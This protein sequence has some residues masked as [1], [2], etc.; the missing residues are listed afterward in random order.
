VTGLCECGCGEAAPIARMTRKSRGHVK[1]QPVRFI[2]GHRNR[3]REVSPQT[4]AKISASTLGRKV[5]DETRAKLSAAGWKGDDANYFS[6]HEWLRKHYPKTGI[7]EEC[8]AKGPTDFAFQ[9]HPE[10][11][12]RNR[13]DYAEW[14]RSCHTA[15]DRE[16]DEQGRWVAA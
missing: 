10:P 6:K 16:R 15:V 13:E 3:G 9:H 2:L 14:C 11:H 12:T 4:R 1:G 7:C 8:G 5:S